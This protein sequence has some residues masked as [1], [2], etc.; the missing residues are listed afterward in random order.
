MNFCRLGIVSVLVLAG[1]SLVSAQGPPAAPKL[2][3]ETRT[4]W[5]RSDANYLRYWLMAGP[6]PGDLAEDCFKG[7][8]GEA[9]LRPVDGQEQ[10]TT[11][12]TKVRWH[13]NRSWGDDANLDGDQM[14]PRPAVAYAFTRIMRPQAGKAM[15]SLGSSNGI[16]V[17]VNGNLVLSRDGVRSSTPDEDQVEVEMKSGENGLLVKALAGSAI[18]ARILGPGSVLRRKVEI[19]PSI[20]KLSSDGF[21]LKTDADATRSAADAVKV[22]VIRPGGAAV[23]GTTAARGAQIAIDA[24]DWPDGPYEVRCSTHS[25]S[26]LLHAAHL[27]W[28]KGDFRDKAKELQAAAAVADASRPEGFTLRMLVDMMEDRLGGKV[29][30]V[31]GNPWQ[32]VHSPL[33]EYDELMLERKGLTGR[34]RPH[35]F[36]RIAYRDEVDG[37]PQYCRAYLPADYDAARKWPVVI[38]I[39]GYNP[40]NPVYV[41]WWAADERHSHCDTEFSNHQGVIYLEPH[42][43]GNTQYIGMGDKDIMTVIAEAKKVFNVDE[44][45]IYLTGDSMGGW[46]TWNVASRHPDLFA[47][48]AP[49]FGGSDYHVDLAEDALTKLSP[50]ERFINEKVSTWSMADGLLNMPIFVHHGDADQAVNVEYS[51]WAVRMLQRWGYNVRYREYPGR[52]HEALESQNG[53]LNIEWFL[54]HRRDHNPHHVRIRTAELRHASAYWV[55]I[56]QFASPSAFMVV[57]AEV[58]DGNVIRLDTENILDIVLTPPQALVDLTKKVTV[59]WNGVRNEMDVKNG[60]LHLTAPEYHPTALRKTVQLPGSITDFTVTPFALVIGTVS[61]DPGMVAEC[62]ARATAFV[63]G[64]REWQKQQPRVFADTAISAADMASYSLLLIGGPEAN[65]VTAKLADRI[66]LRISADR[67]TID[68]REFPVKDAALHM[69]YPSPLNPERYVW[70]AAGTSA[71]GMYFTGLNPQRL[72]AWDYARRNLDWDYI[73]A[74]GTIPAAGERANDLQLRVVSGTFDNTWH[75]TDALSQPGDAA[76]RAHGRLRHR[77][78]AHLAVNPKRLASFVGRYQLSGGPV[79][80]ITLEGKQLRATMP[81]SP[82]EALIPASEDTFWAESGGVWVSFVSDST[83]MVTGFVGYQDSDFQAAKLQ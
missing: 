73:I 14:A 1:L 36:V 78:D 76:L 29:N 77:P 59:V 42:G 9:T 58:V 3:D 16:R 74:D 67:I 79:V 55:Q 37:S 41:R 15:V 72:Y 23:F 19:G 60:V 53:N 46:G 5:T 25:S 6:I 34:I 4:P 52:V 17:W 20:I 31:K 13:S 39:H 43:R 66:P 48:I 65:L 45:R 27:P 2:K 56:H 24:G 38:Q 32:R 49:V 80:L 11:N 8:G 54:Q 10:A 35:G 71:D 50:T 61:K 51:R 22:E 44:D 63:S 40:A 33:M 30:S 81:G 28:Y 47:A 82:G 62:R 21:T 12:G 69:I 70:I 68:G 18:Y 57:D 75:Y 83:G 7:K 64:W 26:G